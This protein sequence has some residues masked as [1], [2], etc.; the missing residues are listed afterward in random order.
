MAVMHLIHNERTKLS[1]TWFNT[2]ATALLA[3]G[4]FAPLA[5]LL[6]GIADMRLERAYVFVL[7][8]LCGG[9]GVCLHLVGRRFL[10]RLRE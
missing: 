5:A 7:A 2:L 9:G 10:G 6:Y 8:T 1:A 4:G 3:A